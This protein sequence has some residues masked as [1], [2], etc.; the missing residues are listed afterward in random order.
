MQKLCGIENKTKYK[1]KALPLTCFW[2]TVKSQ[3][4]GPR[5]G[6]TRVANPPPGNYLLTTGRVDT[7]PV[8][9]EVGGVRLEK[10]PE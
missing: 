10:N 9:E 1:I 8:K 5:Q 7:A 3:A 2:S 4:G 6:S